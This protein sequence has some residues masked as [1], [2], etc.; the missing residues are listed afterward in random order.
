MWNLTDVTVR[1][2]YVGLYLWRST[3]LAI[4]IMNQ[5]IMFWEGEG[6]MINEYMIYLW[7]PIRQT[8]SYCH[9][10]HCDGHVLNGLVLK[11]SSTQLHMTF[12]G[13]IKRTIS[14]KTKPTFINLRH[15]VM[16]FSS[17]RT[18][19]FEIKHNPL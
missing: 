19:W 13:L 11:W 15:N 7:I 10:H 6:S 12:S 4:I 2:N 9:Y 3:K 1:E 14:Q 8:W 5:V 17:L 18:W 16:T